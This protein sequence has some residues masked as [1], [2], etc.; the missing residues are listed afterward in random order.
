MNTQESTIT[1]VVDNSAGEGLIAEHG[2][3]MLIEDGDSKVLFDTGQGG[4]LANNL[5]LLGIDLTTIDTLVL[6]HGHYDHTGALDYVLARNRNMTIYCHP[7][8]VMPRVSIH[9]PGK[10]HLIG[11]PSASKAAFNG[12]MMREQI[13][14]TN[15]PVKL[16]EQVGCTGPVPR[17]ND[18]EDTGGP[19]FLDSEG[20]KQDLIDDDQSIWIKTPKG[21]VLILG[22]C[23]AGVI[24][25]ID[26]VKK[27]T[28]ET[29]I[30]AIIGGMHLKH[31]SDDRLDKTISALQQISPNLIVPCHCTGEKATK[32][33]AAAFPNHLKPGHSG[34]SFSVD[35]T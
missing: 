20:T 21:L 5:D 4:A 1:I 18:F 22:C 14:W 30:H 13:R 10:P 7:V 11:M 33:L 31:A 12:A 6:S 25:T 28:G 34:W 8:V 9:E 17:L 15:S 29:R 19:F 24:N 35:I 27:I 16:T 32:A 23:H 3:A 2:L 26:Y